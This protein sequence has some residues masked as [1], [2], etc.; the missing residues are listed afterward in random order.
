MSEQNAVKAGWYKDPSNS[1]VRRYYDGKEWTDDTHT[2][3][4]VAA[5]PPTPA[6][7]GVS[8]L[9]LLIGATGY[10]IGLYNIN[11]NLTEKGFY[12]TVFL[13]GLFGA[14]AVSKSVRDKL[15]NI[16]VSSLFYGLSWVAAIIPILFIVIALWNA[17]MG[18][19]E[20][21]FYGMSISLTMF[22]TIA[23]QKNVRDLQAAKK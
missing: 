16:P 8:W 1:S 2:V 9:A 18:V 19:S 10:L 20:K 22:A 15:E 21:G 23:I 6:F 17:D 4:N 11:L 14:V 5:M 13:F 7:V 3:D 12:V